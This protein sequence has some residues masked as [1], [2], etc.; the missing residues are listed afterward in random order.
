M[1][2]DI[3]RQ[4]RAVAEH[5]PPTLILD[6]TQHTGHGFIRFV[7]AGAIVWDDNHVGVKGTDNTIYGL[8]DHQVVPIVPTGSVRWTLIAGS[9][10]ALP[11]N[12]RCQS[13]NEV[14]SSDVDD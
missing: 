9:S 5:L 12:L 7:P 3:N 11:S 13:K 6:E 10:D 4:A 14:T 2:D 8:H 1:T